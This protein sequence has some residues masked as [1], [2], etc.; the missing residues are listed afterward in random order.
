MTRTRL[1]RVR[2]TDVKRNQIL[3]QTKRN[4]S[5][6]LAPDADADQG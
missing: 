2:A 6:D 4:R 5:A 1:D 3:R